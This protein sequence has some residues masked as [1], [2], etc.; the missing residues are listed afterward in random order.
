MKKKFDHSL[1]DW[2]KQDI[3]I[4]EEFGVSRERIR[5]LRKIHKQPAPPIRIWRLKT[6]PK[7]GSLNHFVINNPDLI[8]D[9]TIPEIVKLLKV[10]K[11]E[12]RSLSNLYVILNR[13]SLPYKRLIKYHDWANVNFDLPNSIIAQIWGIKT[14]VVAVHRAVHNIPLAKWDIRFG[15]NKDNPDLLAAAEHERKKVKKIS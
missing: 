10:N 4:S 15:W 6:G 7:E 13:T 12:M 14:S 1:I 8:R 5:Q 11:I 2:N 3:I 9:K